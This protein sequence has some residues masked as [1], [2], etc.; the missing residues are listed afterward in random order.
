MKL[1]ALVLLLAAAPR[2]VTVDP[3]YVEMHDEKVCRD[4]GAGKSFGYQ[5]GYVQIPGKSIFTLFCDTADF[6]WDNNDAVPHWTRH[7]HPPYESLKP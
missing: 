4:N 2:S 7:N 3:Q 6:V 5:D 1:L